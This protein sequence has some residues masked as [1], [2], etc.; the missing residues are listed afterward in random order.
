MVQSQLNWNTKPTG[1]TLSIVNREAFFFF[2]A[3]FWEWRR[4]HAA[5]Q[6]HVVR[7]EVTKKDV[8]YAGLVLSTIF[9]I[10]K[11]IQLTAL[12]RLELS[13]TPPAFLMTRHATKA[14]ESY[15]QRS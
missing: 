1:A 11:D 3:G 4:C 8:R 12:G 13:P 7:G 15:T 14:V 2:S 10:Y 9:D 6:T 5:P